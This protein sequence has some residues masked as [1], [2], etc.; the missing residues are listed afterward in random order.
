MLSKFAIDYLSFSHHGNRTF[1]H[2]TDDPIEAEDF[3]MQLLAARAR[4]TAIRHDGAAMTAKQFDRMLKVASE[5]IS[6]ELLRVSLG[7][8]PSE[9]KDRFG[10]AA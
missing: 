4:I 9:I 6:S 5:R 2:L 8:D 7:L 10:F 3:L 1:T